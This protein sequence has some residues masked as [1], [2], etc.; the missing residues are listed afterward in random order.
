LTQCSGSYNITNFNFLPIPLPLY[1]PFFNATI[2]GTTNVQITGGNIVVSV[3]VAVN[4]FNLTL[5]TCEL[6]PCPIKA[7][8]FNFNV[9]VN[10][11][12]DISSN[13]Q[14]LENIG[15]NITAKAYDAS[16]NILGCIQGS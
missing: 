9:P 1:L 8:P 16:E 4:N 13:C 3:F 14:I 5:Q 15:A 10:I 2:S 11:S 6:A 12:K 7:G